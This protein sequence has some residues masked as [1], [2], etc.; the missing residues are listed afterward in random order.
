MELNRIVFPRPLSSYSHETM[1]GKL[2]YIPKYEILENPNNGPL[3]DRVD[4]RL[5]V[6]N[7]QQYFSTASNIFL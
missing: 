2:I 4:N 3:T 6:H 7:N 1:K 5:K